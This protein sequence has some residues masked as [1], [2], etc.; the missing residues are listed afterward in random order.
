[1]EQGADGAVG[2]G[3]GP[4]VPEKAAADVRHP[5]A[6]GGPVVGP[7]A[8]TGLGV[9]PTQQTAPGGQAE[10]PAGQGPSAAVQYIHVK[11]A[12][13]GVQLLQHHGLLLYDP[14]RKADRQ[15]GLAAGDRVADRFLPQ[16]AGQQLAQLGQPLVKHLAQSGGLLH[17]PGHVQPKAEQAGAA[18]FQQGL[19]AV[20]PV[21][22]ALQHLLQRAGRPLKH[23]LLIHV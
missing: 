17:R 9:P 15:Q 10:V 23:C 13:Q 21:R 11:Q 6:Q 7:A 1:M 2:I 12:A 22:A 5:V 20:L 18:L 8:A 4:L 19:L 14:R 16:C 3:L